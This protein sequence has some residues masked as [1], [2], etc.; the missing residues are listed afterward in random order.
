LIHVG[1]QFIA[2]EP[3]NGDDD[4][5]YTVLKIKD[6]Y[7]TF[8]Y[9]DNKTT[10]YVLAEAEHNLE[11][12][13]WTVIQSKDPLINFQLIDKTAMINE[14]YHIHIMGMGVNY[15]GLDNKVKTEI[16]T[17]GRKLTELLET[18]RAL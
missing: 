11:S 5:I 6:K 17:I 9:D 14:L 3:G 15:S 13:K 18:F 12:K 8:S 2:G 16:K 1:L 7:V 4:T 10:N